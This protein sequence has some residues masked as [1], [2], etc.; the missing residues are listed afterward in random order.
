[1]IPLQVKLAHQHN[2]SSL[3]P[4]LVVEQVVRAPGLALQVPVGPQV[5][6]LTHATSEWHGVPA[7]AASP[8]TQLNPRPP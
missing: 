4:V 8:S 5:P 6:E 3:A 7:G 2:T 1:M